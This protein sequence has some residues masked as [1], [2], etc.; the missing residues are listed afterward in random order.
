MIH[1]LLPVSH[2]TFFSLQRMPLYMEQRFNLPEDGP[3]GAWRLF[4]LLPALPICI[5]PTSK[6]YL[7][8]NRGVQVSAV[9]LPV[10][11]NDAAHRRTVVAKRHSGVSV[12]NLPK[13]QQFALIRD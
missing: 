12:L 1:L 2:C 5:T 8:C 3:G 6:K 4:W 9:K 13:L 7:S 10:S 11:L